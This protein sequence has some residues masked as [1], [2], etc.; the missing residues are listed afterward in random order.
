MKHV[1]LQYKVMGI[2]NWVSAT[3]SHEIARQLEIE[4]KDYGWPVRILELDSKAAA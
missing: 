1:T 3:V 2:G 4:Y